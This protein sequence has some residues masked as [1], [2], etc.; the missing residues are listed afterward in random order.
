QPRTATQQRFWK[1]ASCGKIFTSVSVRS[2]SRYH[3]C[4]SALKTCS[5]LPTAFL[6][7]STINTIKEFETFRP[8]LFC[9]WFATIGLGTYA[10]SRASLSMPCFFVQDINCCLRVYRKN[11]IGRE[12]LVL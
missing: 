6:S 5:S 2:R 10:N 11:F 12:S 8:R 4:A 7:A 1:K 9:A 3:H